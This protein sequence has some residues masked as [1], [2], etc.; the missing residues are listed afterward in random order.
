[1]SNK[2]KLKDALQGI[3]IIFALITSF[4]GLLYILKG[5]I[6][7]SGLI[8]VILVILHG[9]INRELIKSRD[10][11]SKNKLSFKS[12][13]LWVSYA[14]ICLPISLFLVHCLNVEI[15]A[16]KDIQAMANAKTNLL[17]EMVESYKDSVKKDLSKLEVDLNTEFTTLAA[18]KINQ[19][20]KN[21]ILV[22]LEDDRED[23][24]ANNL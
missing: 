20:E 18:P 21:K 14:I 3:G 1:M 4:L 19:V 2:L 16:K 15:C 10:E 7:I 13:F 9:Y 17:I 24:E 23:Q 6:L 8:S 22:K 11:I 5:D 12:I